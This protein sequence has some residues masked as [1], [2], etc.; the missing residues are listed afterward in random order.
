MHPG[1]LASRA[2]SSIARQITPGVTGCPV[3]D[4]RAGWILPGNHRLV[5]FAY[6]DDLFVFSG[7]PQDRSWPVPGPSRA[8]R[9]ELADVKSRWLLADSREARAIFRR[10]GF[11]DPNPSEWHAGWHYRTGH[12]AIGQRCE[13]R[14]WPGHEPDTSA[15]DNGSSHGQDRPAC[16]V[17]ESNARI[18][19]ADRHS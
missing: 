3:P 16:Q 1:R 9:P 18:G 7:L 12:E 19:R 10:V 14:P 5:T 2:T 6:L 15:A 4:R 17:F 11:A 13:P 8:R